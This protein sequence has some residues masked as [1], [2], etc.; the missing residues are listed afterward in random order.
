MATGSASAPVDV[1]TVFETIANDTGAAGTAL[2]TISTSINDCLAKL[3]ATSA[4]ASA[5]ALGGASTATAASTATTTP[6]GVGVGGGGS[7]SS[8]T[9]ASTKTAAAASLL[10]SAAEAAVAASASTLPGGGG[11]G[12][13]GLGGGAAEEKITVNLLLSLEKKDSTNIQSCLMVNNGLTIFPDKYKHI[14]FNHQLTFT[15]DTDSGKITLDSGKDTIAANEV[16]FLKTKT[17]AAAAAADEKNINE[18]KIEQLR[19]EKIIEL[20]GKGT[21]TYKIPPV[22]L[23]YN[24]VSGGGVNP[25]SQIVAKPTA[26]KDK[27]K[28]IKITPIVQIGSKSIN[29]ILSFADRTMFESG[30]IITFMDGTTQITSTSET[31]KKMNDALKPIQIT[32][33]GGGKKKRQSR[34]SRK[35]TKK[36]SKGGKKRRQSYRRF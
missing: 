3:N 22:Y 1:K 27:A 20:L 17:A 10:P 25:W 24:A 32:L 21:G 14:W 2:K 9:A 34:K 12:G 18:I 33:L 8:T 36:L 23:Q 26:E 30:N 13:G 31:Y 29:Y 28:T 16:T 15:K 6:S 7:S 4:S 35:Y 5:S 19:I 11:G